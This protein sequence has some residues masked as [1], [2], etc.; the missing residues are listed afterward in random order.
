MYKIG[1]HVVYRLLNVCKVEGIETPSFEKDGE[2]RYYKLCPAFENKSNTVI[3]VP[4]NEKDALRALSGKSEAEEAL[5]GLSKEKPVVCLAKKP[6]QLTS[7][8]QEILASCDLKKYL[9]LIKEVIL[10]EKENAKKLSEIDAKYRDKT[11][12]LVCEE[13]AV[14]LNESLETVKARINAACRV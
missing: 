13:F 6:P 1:D 8:Y 2:K 4:V 3:Y 7:Y 5:K 9:A 12:R 10:K 11:L 14:A